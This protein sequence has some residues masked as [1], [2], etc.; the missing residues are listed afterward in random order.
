MNKNIPQELLKQWEKESERLYPSCNTDMIIEKVEA[1]MER[2]AY[3][4]GRKDQYLSQSSQPKGA[5]EVAYKCFIEHVGGII[6]E[7]LEEFSVSFANTWFKKAMQSYASQQLSEKDKEIAELKKSQ[8]PEVSEDRNPFAEL[9]KTCS[10]EELLAFQGTKITRSEP[11]PVQ[12]ERLY[13]WVKASERLPEFDG[14]VFVRNVQTECGGMWVAAEL[15]KSDGLEN[16]EW[17]EELPS[18]PKANK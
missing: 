13:R 6:D 18:P 3:V 7:S 12:G 1:S 8:Q 5:E 10:P 4:E 14:Y 16:M 9:L 11:Q 15:R 2:D 17:L